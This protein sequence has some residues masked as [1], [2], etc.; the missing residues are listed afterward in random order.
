MAEL[1]SLN[2]D[3]LWPVTPKIIARGKRYGNIC[4]CV[5][6]LLCY[7]AETGTPL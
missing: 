4:V 3:S 7:K 6:D 1:N 5:A 2:R